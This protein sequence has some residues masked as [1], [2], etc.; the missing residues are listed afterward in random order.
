ME[1]YFVTLSA[2]KAENPPTLRVI[3][4]TQHDVKKTPEF[5]STNIDDSIK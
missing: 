3:I 4:S 1:N 2:E 5:R